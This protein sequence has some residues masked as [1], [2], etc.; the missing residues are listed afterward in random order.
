MDS[1]QLDDSATAR[2][3]AFLDGIGKT[4]KDKR[5]RASLA[6]YATGL[7]C[8]GDRK[9]M[10]PIAARSSGDPESVLA[11]H[12]RLVH[13]LGSAAW[14]D[15]PVR[16]FSAQYAIA[17]MQTQAPIQTWIVD[18][19]GFLKQGKHS[20]GVQRQYTGTA[21]KTA[22]CQIGVSLVLA[23]EYAH[24]PA[25]FRL[26]LPESWTND[27][28]RCRQAHIP[29]DC[30]YA[31][32][33]ALA[34]EMIETALHAGLPRGVV[35]ADCGYGNT[36]VFRDTLDTLGLQYAVEIQSMTMVQSVHDGAALADRMSVMKLGKMLERKFRRVT[37]REGSKTTLHSR[38]A[39]IRV[40]VARDD[41]LQREP[42][43]LLVEWPE[44]EPSPTK[45][46]LSNLPASISCVQLVRTFKCRWR[47][48]RSYE[49]LKGELGLDHYEG[50]SWV[51]WHHHVSVVLACYAFLVAEQ[52]RSFPPSFAWPSEYGSFERPTR[53]TLPRFPHH[54]PN[55]VRP[56]GSPALASAL[57]VLPAF[58]HPNDQPSA[59]AASPE[60]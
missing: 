19:T 27:P 10:E 58:V 47:I 55:P 13:F 53:A 2:M 59:A 49:D 4:L 6:M 38:F 11:I 46:A 18:D 60:R 51:G 22:N 42:E 41:G 25:D 48:E 33:W 29:S 39:R 36:T 34:L 35:L 9:S 44:G 3:N 8:D 26:Y 30:Q 24:V 28:A 57:P 14:A 21:G 20:P 40:V 12:H 54:H 50:R 17:A 5:Q 32:K 16:S 7:L 45:F 23:N 31:P 37:W 15:A 43:W 56:R 1:T 52:V